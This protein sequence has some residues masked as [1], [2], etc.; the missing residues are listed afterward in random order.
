MRD[1]RAFHDWVRHRRLDCDCTALAAVPHQED[2]DAAQ[3]SRHSTVNCSRPLSQVRVG[4]P[5]GVL[6]VAIA[7]V[8]VAASPSSAFT[9]PARPAARVEGAGDAVGAWVDAAS[10]GAGEAGDATAAAGDAATLQRRNRGEMT[11]GNGLARRGKDESG[12]TGAGMW[13]P[14]AAVLAMIGAAAYFARRW[15]P[16]VG[17]RIGGSS[18][19]VVA[20]HHLSSKQSLCLVRLGRGLVLLGVTPDRIATVA[21]IQDPEEVAEIVGSVERNRAGSFSKSLNAVSGIE[22]EHDPANEPAE[23]VIDLGADRLNRAGSDI[24]D[25]VKRVRSITGSISTSTE[26]M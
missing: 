1:T 9:D 14:T 24:R 2:A 22:P 21:Q 12:L 18:I 5:H 26:S 7:C 25:L 16:R 13:W 4:S 15:L 10:A 17:P 3:L 23:P 8:C 20:R 19:K 11:A 6:V